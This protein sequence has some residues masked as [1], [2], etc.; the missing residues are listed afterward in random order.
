MQGMRQ[1]QKK[2]ELIE[3]VVKDWCKI[4]VGAGFSTGWQC[5]DMLDTL[6]FEASLNILIKIRI[7]MCGNELQF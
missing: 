6:M 5:L 1:M 2:M 7:T 3:D 4:P